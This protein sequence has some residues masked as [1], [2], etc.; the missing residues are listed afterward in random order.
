MRYLIA[1]VLSLF[2]SSSMAGTDVENVRDVVVDTFTSVSEELQT[3]VTQ[4]DAVDIINEHLLNMLDLPVTA[5]IVIG[6]HW[7]TAS[8]DQRTRFVEA[9]QVMM[10]RSYSRFLIGEDA[11]NVDMKVL[12]TTKKGTKRILAR[13]RMTTPD[14]RS[15]EVDYTFYFNTK[16]DKWLVIDVAVEGISVALSYRS[17]YQREIKAKGIDSLISQMEAK[18]IVASD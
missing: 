15:F 2:L 13:T 5:R 9:F 16:R 4:E 6:K 11:K 18:N 8:P 7:R 17:G 14:G 12:R 3:A 1:F 10:I